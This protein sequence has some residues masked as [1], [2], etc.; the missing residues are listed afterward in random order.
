[1]YSK[2]CAGS[3]VNCFRLNRAIRESTGSTAVVVTWSF[4]QFLDLALESPIDSTK[5]EWS[6]AMPKII[7]SRLAKNFSNS[8]SIWL[9]DWYKETTNFSYWQKLQK[10]NIHWNTGKIYYSRAE[11]HE[12]RHTHANSP[13]VSR[14]ICNRQWWVARYQKILINLGTIR[15]F[16]CVERLEKI[17]FFVKIYFL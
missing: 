3:F 12:N 16:K 14:M 8:S 9:V 17:Y 2:I 11:I 13:Y 7:F 1:M 10:L 6:L 4:D 5:P 15:L